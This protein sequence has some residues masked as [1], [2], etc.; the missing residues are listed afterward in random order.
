MT[1]LSKCSVHWPGH[2]GYRVKLPV[3]G[4]LLTDTAG[5][6]R[7][8]YDKLNEMYMARITHSQSSFTYMYS[9][10]GLWEFTQALQGKVSNYVP[11]F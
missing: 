10:A 1:Q 4:Q 7:L 9:R 2:N 3:K 11:R 5:A 6:V 8:S